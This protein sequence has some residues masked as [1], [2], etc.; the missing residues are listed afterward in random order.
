MAIENEESGV[1]IRVRVDSENDDGKPVTLLHFE[2]ASQVVMKLT[3]WAWI[4][5][6]TVLVGVALYLGAKWA[7]AL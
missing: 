2:L 7:G 6:G 5:T 3:R 4:A 1:G